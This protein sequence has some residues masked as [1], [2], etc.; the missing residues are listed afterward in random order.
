MPTV[1]ELRAQAAR[2]GVFPQDEDLERVQAFLEVVLP[3]LARLEELVPPDTV[4]A[5]MYLPD[6]SP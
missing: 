3:A 1:D 6:G 4:P 5:G 2:V